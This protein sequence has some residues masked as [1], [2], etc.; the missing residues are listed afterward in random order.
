MASHFELLVGSVSPEPPSRTGLRF[1]GE[2][3]AASAGLGVPPR[4]ATLKLSGR[5]FSSTCGVQ[6]GQKWR[7]EHGL[8]RSGTE[9][10]PM[11]D[12]P[13]WSFEDGRPAPPLKGQIRRRQEKETLAVSV[14]IEVSLVCCCFQ[15]DL[16]THRFCAVS[17]QRRIV[18]LNSEVDYGVEAWN[19]KQ[20][21]A[22]RTEEHRK[23]L[24]LKPKGKLLMKKSKS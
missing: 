20:E 3:A 7:L 8:A 4:A 1:T 17:P 12:L 19:K 24:L 6:A 21:E 13:D 14:S 9:Y 11:T 23:S 15:F 5:H 2:A 10:G 16:R 18:M 22:R